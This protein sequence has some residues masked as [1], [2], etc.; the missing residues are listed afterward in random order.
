MRFL[1]NSA[2][3]CLFRG[4]TRGD[5]NVY[6]WM[7]LIGDF[8]GV[9]FISTSDLLLMMA[10][11]VLLVILYLCTYRIKRLRAKLGAL[12]L[13]N[14][15]I[16][17]FMEIYLETTLLSMHN[18]KNLEWRPDTPLYTASNL[19]AIFFFALVFVLPIFLLYF[20]RKRI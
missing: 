7:E 15:L 8:I 10:L 16:R 9:G 12:L 6:Y 5:L 4:E 13:W 1:G 20:F 17:L 19:L 18:L 3:R 11:Y 14:G 2:G